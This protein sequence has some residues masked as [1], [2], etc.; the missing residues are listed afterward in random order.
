[1]IISRR[2]LIKIASLSSSALVFAGHRRHHHRLTGPLGVA[3]GTPRPDGFT[4]WTGLERSSAELITGT[5]RVA[6]DEFFSPNS[7]VAT[8]PCE[9][10]RANDFTVHIDVFGLR[11]NQTFYYQFQWPSSQSVVG[12]ARTLPS[13]GEHLS[14]LKFG[15]VCCQRYSEGYFSALEVL[16][17]QPNINFCIN[18]G[19]HI[20]ES[21]PGNVR[22]VP[23]FKDREAVSLEDYRDQYRLYLSDPSLQEVRR[24]FTWI[25]LMDDHEV[26]NDYSGV[27]DRKENAARVAAAYHAFYEFTPVSSEPFI[28]SNGLI[29][30]NSVESYEFGDLAHMFKMDQRQFRMPNPCKKSFVTARCSEA[31][32]P[33]HAMIGSQ[34]FNWLREGLEHTEARWKLL[35]S[36]VMLTRLKIKMFNQQVNEFVLKRLVDSPN[37]KLVRD[38]ASGDT[39][40]NL[41][42]WDGYPAERDRLFEFIQSRR[43]ANVVAITGDIHAAAH[44]RLIRDDAPVNSR[45]VAY[46]IVT[47][48]VTSDTL[49]EKLGS[50]LG[51]LSSQIIRR[52]NPYLE[53]CDTENHGFTVISLTHESL[54]AEHFVVH[55]ITKPVSSFEVVKTLTLH[56]GFNIS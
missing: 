34:Q 26:F 54:T 35:L 51:G 40:L 17:R 22:P 14:Q 1:V 30:M 52:S 31:E 24:K 41:D 5:Y 49:E 28:D 8:G 15:V 46:E 7:I 11:S 29:A 43:I 10:H 25:D 3:S 12:R 13:S 20:Y 4:I 48:S 36:E 56:E 27:R 55:D 33:S 53:W 42:A 38:I 37:Y 21:E 44:A 9:A 50:I 16:A 45:P 32:K 23:R 18:L 6:T 47:T 19:D 39:Y 2:S